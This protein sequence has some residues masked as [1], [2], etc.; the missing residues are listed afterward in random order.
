MQSF[1]RW[2]RFLLAFVVVASSSA[3]AGAPAE[4]TAQQ[5]PRPVGSGAAFLPADTAFYLG[6]DLNPQAEYNRLL[7]R[8]SAI[9]TGAPE[10]DATARGVSDVLGID[11]KVASLLAELR[12]ILGGEIFLAIPDKASLAR[13]TE[14]TP[15]PI[16]RPR[17]RGS[18]GDSEVPDL[19]V[20][21]E[22]RNQAALAEYLGRVRKDVEAAGATVETERADGADLVTVSAKSGEGRIYLAINRGYILLSTARPMLLEATRRTPAESLA[23]AEDFVAARTRLQASRPAMALLFMEVPEEALRQQGGPVAQTIPTRWIGATLDLAPDQILVRMA[24]GMD[25]STVSPAQRALLTR[26][27]LALNS[28]RAVPANTTFFVASGGLKQLWDVM[29]ETIWPDPESYQQMRNSVVRE[30]GL[31]PQDDIFGWMTGEFAF[32]LSP[33]SDDKRS[34]IENA[35]FGLLVEA[36][37]QSLVRAKL[38]KIISAIRKASGPNRGNEQL[39]AAGNTFERIELDRDT[40]LLIGMADRW[41][42]FT[43]NDHAAAGVSN[44]V[45]G[46]G[47]LA[48]DPEFI[49]IRQV[50]ADPVN[51]LGYANVPEIVR[52]T[53]GEVSATGRASAPTPGQN[54]PLAGAGLASYTTLDQFNGAFV[55]HLVLPGQ[56]PTTPGTRPSPAQVPAQVPRR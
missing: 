24:G 43:I 51:F 9:Y 44:A 13:L 47:S 4:V 41:A 11:L 40:P 33:P 2:A 42:T 23:A 53:T 31:D 25:T 52:I 27:P 36:Q 30:T 3:L 10:A 22:I 18:R 17:R 35:G 14:D 1:P 7:D 50:L 26:P 16:T 55:A 46:R 29:A 15:N 54:I 19:L 5:G 28:A 49:R 32:F 21:A 37:D 45:R 8:L 48:Q 38:D 12:P 6:L 34:S 56:A 39:E 20:G